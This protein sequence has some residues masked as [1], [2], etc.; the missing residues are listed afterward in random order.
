MPLSRWRKILVRN[1]KSAGKNEISTH[2]FLS[3]FISHANSLVSVTGR[4]TILSYVNNTKNWV[5]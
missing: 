1:F 4:L 5:V 2:E 3:T